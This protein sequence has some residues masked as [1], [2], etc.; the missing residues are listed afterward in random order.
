[1]PVSLALSSSI[2][3]LGFERVCLRRAVFGLGLGLFLIPWPRALRLRPHLCLAALE[4]LN[5]CFVNENHQKQ[6]K[7][8]T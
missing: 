6:V 5:S 3:T 7:N 4:C 1:M 2:S 8:T